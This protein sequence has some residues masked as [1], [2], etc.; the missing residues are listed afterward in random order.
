MVHNLRFRSQSVPHATTWRLTKLSLSFS[1][2]PSLFLSVSHIKVLGLGT[3]QYHLGDN[4]LSVK[5]L[6]LFRS[7]S[8]IK[9]LAFRSHSIPPK[10]QFVINQ[11]SLSLSSK[12]WDLGPSQCYQEDNLLSITAL[13]L[14]LS[15]SLSSK[16]WVLGPSQCYQEDNLLSIK[17]LSL[18]HQSPGI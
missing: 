3:S 5:T 11:S 8:S 13:S 17:T 14:S 7:L 2:S 9:V 4:L 10:R 12:S 15:L 1:L 6:S 16:S 18:F